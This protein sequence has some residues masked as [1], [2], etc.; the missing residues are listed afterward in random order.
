VPLRL[1]PAGSLFVIFRKPLN[2][3]QPARA[4]L[5][6]GEPLVTSDA[7]A[8]APERDAAPGSF[9]LAALVKPDRDIPLP[10]QAPRGVQHQNQNFIIFPTHGNTWGEGH[11]GAGFSAGRNGVAVF[12]HWHQ[13]IAPVLVW[14]APAPL[15]RAAHIAVVYTAGTPSLFVDGK[16]VATGVASG[17]TPHRSEGTEGFVGTCEAR[18]SQPGI[19]TD[20]DVATAAARAQAGSGSGS[21]TP[22]SLTFGVDGNLVLAASRAGRYAA[23]LA[24]GSTRTWQIKRAPVRLPL[25]GTRW[26]VTFQ[27]EASGPF[28]A[29]FN[30]LKDWKDSD[31]VRIKYFSGTAAYAGRFSWNAIRPD[32][33]VWLDLGDVRNIASATLNG[34]ALGTLWKKPFRVDVTDALRTGDNLLEVRVANDWFNRFIGDE[35]HPDDTGANASGLLAAW[36][37]WMLKGTP[38]P[39]TGRQTLVNRKQVKKDTPLHAS[40]LL[41]PVTLS[42]E[43]TLR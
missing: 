36:P 34:R 12:E 15:D 18:V 11:S 24:D 43:R 30:G 35:Q 39:E 21:A 1:D 3:R 41:G 6:D 33:R 4:L 8:A 38:R 40:G 17:Q 16:K 28:T 42:E 2:G 26:V 13:N 14:Q 25:D 9:M 32:T 19:I 22:P 23:T 31:D 5:R 20:S 10:V 27:N 29:F 7:L 37:E